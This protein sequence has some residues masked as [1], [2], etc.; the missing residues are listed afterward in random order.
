M[1]ASLTQMRV[2]S[3]PV[4]LSMLVITLPAIATEKSG[5]EVF[6]QTCI[7]CHGT[8]LLGAPRITDNKR[9]K[10]LVSEGMDDLVPAALNGVRNMPPKG[11]NPNLSD[12]EVANAVIWM[13]NQ[14]GANLQP[15]TPAQIE[16]WRHL[17]NNRKK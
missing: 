13:S 14:H 3:F 17:A 8:G 10:K 11:N 2:P 5:E 15:A 12:K 9:W 1:I 6:N 7:V 16:H 4:F